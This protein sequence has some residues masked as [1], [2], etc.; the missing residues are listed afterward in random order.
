MCSTVIN[1]GCCTV[2]QIWHGFPECRGNLQFSHFFQWFNYFKRIYNNPDLYCLFTERGFKLLKA[3]GLQS[4][5]MPNKWMLVAYGKPARKFLA[6]TGFSK[7]SI[8]AIFSF[9]MKPQPTFAFL[10]P[11]AEHAPL[12]CKFFRSI[13]KPIVAIL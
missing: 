3:G 5:I 9:L 10:S 7:Y 6:K 2:G 8:L 13:G 12:L 1:P 11:A 4:F